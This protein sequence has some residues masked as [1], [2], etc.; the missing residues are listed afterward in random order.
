MSSAIKL[1]LLKCEY[2]PVSLIFFDNKLNI[3]E[4]WT[5]RDM[6]GHYLGLNPFIVDSYSKVHLSYIH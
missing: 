2:H 6:C 3:F 4:L 1:Q 5:R